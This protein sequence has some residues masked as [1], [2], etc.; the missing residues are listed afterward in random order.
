MVPPSLP[1]PLPLPKCSTQVASSNS[2]CQKSR[3]HCR[4]LEYFTASRSPMVSESVSKSI[5]VFNMPKKNKEYK[6][7]QE[8][9]KDVTSQ[10]EK[11]GVTAKCRINANLVS[12]KKD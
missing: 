6:K 9:K 3:G 10:K 2:N 12:T 1:I 7:E 8:I 5:S 11:G 4:H